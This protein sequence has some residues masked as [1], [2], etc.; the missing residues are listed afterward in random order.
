MFQPSSG[1]V[2]SNAGR[3]LA[4]VPANG[5]KLGTWETDQN[6]VLGL[7]VPDNDARVLTKSNLITAFNSSTSIAP[8]RSL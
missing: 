1:A 5:W 7:L 3:Q 4:F 6:S 2:T 8:R